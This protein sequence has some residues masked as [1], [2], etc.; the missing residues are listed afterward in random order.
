MK[1]VAYIK[2]ITEDRQISEE[3]YKRNLKII[4]RQMKKFLSAN[5]TVLY[6][7]SNINNVVALNEPFT[8]SSYSISD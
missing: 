7:P 6:V 5:D 8:P 4:K 3:T 1:I 2:T